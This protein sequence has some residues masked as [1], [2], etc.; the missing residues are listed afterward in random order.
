MN[1][2]IAAIATPL[3]LGGIGIVRISGEKARKIANSIFVPV[4]KQN[5]LIAKGYTAHYGKI[6]YNGEK[7]DEGIALVFAA[8]SSYTGEDVVELSCHGGSYVVKKVL[9]AA[10]SSG[11]RLA[12]A[13]EFTKRAYLNK[14]LTLTEAE[15]VMDIIGAGGEQALLAANAAKE[16][17]LYKKTRVICEALVTAAAHIAAYTDFADEG[18]TELE[19]ELVKVA[20]EKSKNE[21]A[22]LLDTFDKGKIMREGIDCVIV[23]RPNVG[24]STLMNLLSGCE[25]SIVTEIAGTT[26]DIIEETVILGNVL[27]KLTDTAGI[28]TTHDL[29]ESIGVDRA[30][31]RLFGAAI[32]LAVFDASEALL[33]EDIEILEMLQNKKA[34][35]LI[36]KTDLPTKME[37]DA[38]KPY[39]KTVFISATS[40]KGLDEL[41][42]AL[43]EIT[44]I[45]AL[46]P[47]AATIATE[48]QK[49][50]IMKANIALEKAINDFNQMQNIDIVG[51]LLDEAIAALLELSGENVSEAVVDEVFSRFC[52]GK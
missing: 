8:P 16:G 39:G 9:R 25:R 36:N 40:G 37:L 10:L 6:V 2:T 12:E 17:A 21:L 4:D 7:V 52:I 1:D 50:C 35:I 13:G 41:T 45:A 24:K 15:A 38:L 18:E 31:T 27:L 48:R 11:A 22:D 47:N 30:K 46:D 33:P 26:R 20:L 14:K 34:I 3:S 49:S 28:R 51:F 19:T 43:E 23:G 32:V 5:L 44:G 29:V 42:S